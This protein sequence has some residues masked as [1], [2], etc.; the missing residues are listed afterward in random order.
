ML[1]S[2]VRR[3][4][5]LANRPTAESRPP[6][7]EPEFWPLHE[8]CRHATMTSTER[9][10]ALYQA[11]EYVVRHNVPGDFVECGV[12]RGGSV[13]MIALALQKFGATR[14]IHC[15]DTFEGMPPPTGADVQHETGES[16]ASI[17]SRTRRHDDDYMWAVAALDLV[18]KNVESTG[19]PRDLVGYHKGRVEDTLPDRAPEAIALLRL[20]TDWY[21]STKHE[22]AHLYPRLARGG[23]LI[24]D[25]YGFW[26][27]A[28]EATDEYLAQTKAKLFLARI[29]DTGRIG[30]KLA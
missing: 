5:F 25:D 7:L 2:A 21:E 1:R 10:Y 13:M 8:A 6:D 22:L 19:Y 15:F 23:I 3:L 4:G 12:W 16:A 28:R 9:L 30:V 18:K 20:D 17:L 26:R 14:N 29:D 11:V 24:I 27:G